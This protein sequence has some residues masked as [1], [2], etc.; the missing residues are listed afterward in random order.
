MFGEFELE[1]LMQYFRVVKGID[2]SEAFFQINFLI[3][4]LGLEKMRTKRLTHMSKGER[5]QALV[6]ASLV[7]SPKIEVLNK[8]LDGVDYLA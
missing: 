1:E 3:N 5:R 7:G 4:V 2:E 8:P 6:A